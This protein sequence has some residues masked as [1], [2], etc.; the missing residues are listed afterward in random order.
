MIED[1]PEQKS[2]KKKQAF[3]PVSYGSQLFYASQKC[4]RI[5]KNFQLSILR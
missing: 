5:A 3:A 2:G 4:L 1:Y